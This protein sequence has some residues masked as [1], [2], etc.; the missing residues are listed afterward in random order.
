MRRLEATLIWRHVTLIISSVTA[1]FLVLAG[2]QISVSASGD[3]W[4]DVYG[5]TVSTST[6]LQVN[7]AA[8]HG[9]VKDCSVQHIV[10]EVAASI[11]ETDACVSEKAGVG[12][13]VVR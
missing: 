2:A 6:R 8:W 5:V 4:G 1:V 12:V 7:A 3:S 13:A 9:H 10:L 11:Q